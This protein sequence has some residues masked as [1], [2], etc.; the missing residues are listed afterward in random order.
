MD[1]WDKGL[2]VN[3]PF[4]NWVNLSSVLSSHSKL[5]YHHDAVRSADI[6]KISVKNPGS[7]IDVM[8]NHTLQAQIAQ[9]KHILRA[10]LFLAKH[11]LPFHGDI[12]VVD[13]DK[14]PGN[15]LALMKLFA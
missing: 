13:S 5:P 7:R 9:N 6:L 1:R 2:L 3:K 14:N 12:E 8:T 10:I 15:F 4:S 11:G